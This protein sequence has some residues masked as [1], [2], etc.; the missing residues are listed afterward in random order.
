MS[1]TLLFRFKTESVEVILTVFKQI[2]SYKDPLIVL[3]STESIVLF[4]EVKESVL[5]QIAVPVAAL[6]LFSL[7]WISLSNPVT[8]NT[9]PPLDN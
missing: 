5:D 1:I 7:I 3:F 6:I 9:P 4:C 2:P 8:V